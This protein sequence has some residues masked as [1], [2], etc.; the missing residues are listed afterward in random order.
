[1]SGFTKKVTA[2]FAAAAAAT[3]IGLSAG[4][5]FL[6][7]EQSPEDN[8]WTSHTAEE[9]HPM[10][11]ALSEATKSHDERFADAIYQ[12]DAKKLQAAI[13]NGASPDTR[14]L[15]T[16]VL[17]GLMTEHSY[18]Y[19]EH[20][21]FDDKAEQRKANAEMVNILLRAGTDL[22]AP[23]YVSSELR[24]DIFKSS[25]TDAAISA[26]SHSLQSSEWIDLSSTVIIERIKQDILKEKPVYTPDYNAIFKGLGDGEDST[27]RIKT[28]D[29]IAAVHDRVQERLQDPQTPTEKF[30]QREIGKAAFW[31]QDFNRPD[32][33]S[34]PAPRGGINAGLGLRSSDHLLSLPFIIETQG[35]EAHT[36]PKAKAPKP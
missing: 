30:V 16:S 14:L 32:I 20:D 36:T 12:Q 33:G 15:G 35:N 21:A 24:S 6:L 34:L 13:D 10:I 2:I 8:R 17:A 4:R 28:M 25:I 27:T 9:S 22:S 18:L 26:P 1:M 23:A 11:S 3:A 5:Q 7:S 29:A 31:V 19:P